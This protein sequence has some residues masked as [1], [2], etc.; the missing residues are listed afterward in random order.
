MRTQRDIGFI[1]FGVA[2][3]LFVSSLQVVINPSNWG[4]LKAIWWCSI[5]IGFLVAIVLIFI[6]VRIIRRFD[7]RIEEQERERHRAE[8]QAELNAFRE[9][10]RQD[11][12]EFLGNKETKRTK[13]KTSKLEPRNK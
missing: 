11:I 5:A 2:L 6:T 4:P 7:E 1:L 3:A 13:G 12:I 9:G 10:L 8:L